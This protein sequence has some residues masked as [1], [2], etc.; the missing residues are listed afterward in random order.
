MIEHMKYLDKLISKIRTKCYISRFHT[1]FQ[2]IIQRT[3]IFPNRIIPNLI[4]TKLV[5]KLK[6][7]SK[8]LVRTNS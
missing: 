1:R 8:S 5:R 2:D 6:I 3:Y 4:F 7:F